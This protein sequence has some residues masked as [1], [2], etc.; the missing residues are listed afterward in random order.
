M[1]NQRIQ[2]HTPKNQ[3]F[4]LILYIIIK[5]KPNEFQV[6][7]SKTSEMLSFFDE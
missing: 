6:Q 4:L 5:M 3:K 7:Q 1:G 2:S